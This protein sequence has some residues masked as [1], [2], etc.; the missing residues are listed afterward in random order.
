M[1]DFGKNLKQIRLA[2]GATQEQM[3]MM[4]DMT[5]RGYRNYEL[6][7]REPNLSDLVKIADF[8][9]VSLD[10]LVGRDYQPKSSCEE[11]VDGR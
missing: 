8:F 10:D 9:S 11:S 4:L 3:A 5:T 1:I 7:C 6:G 2:M